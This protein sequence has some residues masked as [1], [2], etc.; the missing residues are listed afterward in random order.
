MPAGHWWVCKAPASNALSGLNLLQ[1]E[2]YYTVPIWKLIYKLQACKVI[3]W[4]F[5]AVISELR[6]RRQLPKQ[7]SIHSEGPATGFVSQKHRVDVGWGERKR[8]V[9]DISRFGVWTT[10]WSWTAAAVIF[11]SLA[12]H[13]RTSQEWALN[14]QWLNEKMNEWDKEGT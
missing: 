10:G 3:G 4:A 12:V 7:G 11:S 6:K 8:G 13:N 2:G 1:R 14:Q 5:A 9:K